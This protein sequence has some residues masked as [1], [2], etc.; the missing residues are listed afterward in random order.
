MHQRSKLLL[1]NGLALGAVGTLQ[2]VMDFAGYW[3]GAGPAGGALNGNLYTIGFAE[4]HGLAAIFAALM[5]LRRKD[6]WPGW[7]LA[8]AL[9]HTLLGACNLI[10]WP[11]FAEVG[12]VPVG[13]VATAM[14]IGFAVAQFWAF[15][16]KSP[17]RASPT[18]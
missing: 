13:I 7:H 9:V 16:A 6:G 15:A 17:A 4:A 2:F 18:M 11:L 12:I 8:A 1:V 14:H 5:I 10:F 3:F